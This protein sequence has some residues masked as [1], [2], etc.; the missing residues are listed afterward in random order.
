MKNILQSTY[1]R[2][3]EDNKKSGKLYNRYF[4]K[5]REYEKHM[6]QNIVDES[7]DDISDDVASKYIVM[8]TVPSTQKYFL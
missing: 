2:V 6:K 1:Y 7:F 5:R 4:Y 8:C 3:T